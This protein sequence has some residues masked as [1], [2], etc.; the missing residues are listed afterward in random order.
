LALLYVDLLNSCSKNAEAEAVFRKRERDDD[1][2][3]Q[4]YVQ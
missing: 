1:P 2:L 3:D 4:R